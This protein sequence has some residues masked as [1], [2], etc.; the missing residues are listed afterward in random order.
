MEVNT[1]LSD[2]TPE[3]EQ[4]LIQLLRQAPPWRKLE[5]VGQLNKTVRTLMWSG[6]RE[7]HPHASDVVLRRH[8]ADLWLGSELAARVYGPPQ[9]AE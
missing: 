6:L 7:R 8:L 4:V 3:A 2:T 5:M 1:P 9:T